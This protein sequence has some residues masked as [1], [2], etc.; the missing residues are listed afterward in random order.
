MTTPA[1]APSLLSNDHV[2]GLVPGPI[3]NAATFL[4]FAV[5]VWRG[6]ERSG[7]IGSILVVALGWFFILLAWLFRF[8]AAAG[9][10]AVMGPRLRAPIRW[11]LAPSLFAVAFV[12]VFGG[13]A[14]HTRF[15]IS[16]P[17]LERAA[18][19]A[20]AG[21]APG[22]GWVGLYPV[23]SVSVDA[24][25][26]RIEIDGQLPLIRHNGPLTDDY[27]SGRLYDALD[28]NWSIEYD[29]SFGD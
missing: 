29:L 27:M 13:Y 25:S 19:D 14:Y 20:L 18:A 2:A 23:R 10:G 12:V 4:V 16:R 8:V 5:S 28:D 15:A 9:S 7:D 11:G 17:A 6:S 1:D 21:H 26:V 24:G 22:P 3:L